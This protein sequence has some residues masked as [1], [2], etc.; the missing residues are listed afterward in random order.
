MTLAE[1]NRLTGPEFEAELGGVFEHSPWV[2]SE[3]YAARPFTGLESLHAAMMA[4]VLRASPEKQRALIRAHP[5]LAG[6]AAI[7]A[8]AKGELAVVPA[9]PLAG[10]VLVQLSTAGAGCFEA[11]FQPGGFVQNDPAGFKAKG[12]AP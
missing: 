10:P 11:E 2:A 1:L 3:A 4:A 7:L 6:K 9:L 12:G 8:Q 5:E